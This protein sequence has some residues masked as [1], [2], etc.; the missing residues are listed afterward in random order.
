VNAIAR[1]MPLAA[2]VTTAVLPSSFPFDDMR[3]SYPVE[4]I[5]NDN[6]H[7]HD[8]QAGRSA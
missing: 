2:P 1:P 8:H 6:I 3:T 7:R 5:R 4:D